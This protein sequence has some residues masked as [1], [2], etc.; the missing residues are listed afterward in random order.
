MFKVPNRAFS[1]I[2]HIGV[3]GSGQMGT[4]I[5]ILASS[6]AGLNVT[7][8]NPNPNGKGLIKSQETITKWSK[9]QKSADFMDR[10]TFSSQ[11]D[12]L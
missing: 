6:V 4:G 7:I 12:D 11:I 8:Y 5:G 2:N 9:S 10:I 1:T 3:I